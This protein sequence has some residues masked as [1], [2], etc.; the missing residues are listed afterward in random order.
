MANQDRSSS[1]DLR[2]NLVAS[3]RGVIDVL[4]PKDSQRALKEAE[5]AWQDNEG[6]GLCVVIKREQRGAEKIRPAP[7]CGA[8]VH[9]ASEVQMSTDALNFTLLFSINL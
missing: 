3:E 5:G 6:Q 7:H 2:S 1:D 8:W 9:R 4:H